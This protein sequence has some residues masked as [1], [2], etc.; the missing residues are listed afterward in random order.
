MSWC[1]EQDIIG[2]GTTLN[3]QDEV[4]RAQAAVIL[5]KFCQLR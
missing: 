1:V 2:D 5:Q 3:P 4:T